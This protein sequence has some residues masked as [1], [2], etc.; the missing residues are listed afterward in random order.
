[1]PERVYLQ[2]LKPKFEAM[3]DMLSPA[4]QARGFRQMI[5][6]VVVGKAWALGILR[7]IPV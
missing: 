5:D 2:P 1:M 3:L 4:G 7:P 6:Q